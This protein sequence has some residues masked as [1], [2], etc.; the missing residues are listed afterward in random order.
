MVYVVKSPLGSDEYVKR[1]QTTTSPYQP[2]Q[3]DRRRTSS[4]EGFADEPLTDGDGTWLWLHG[5]KIASEQKRRRWLR[6]TIGVAAAAA[7]LILT[8]VV[9]VICFRMGK[10][11]ADYQLQL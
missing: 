6:Q 8:V 2:Y 10:H 4:D 1:S 11:H 9:L 7:A 5:D 3:G